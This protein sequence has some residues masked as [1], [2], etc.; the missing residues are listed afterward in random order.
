M[1]AKHIICAFIIAIVSLSILST[2]R[3][4]A[5]HPQTSCE[6]AYKNSGCIAGDEICYLWIGDTG[7]YCFYDFSIYWE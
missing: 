4:F 1:K 3:I 2:T 6:E 5:G 7:E